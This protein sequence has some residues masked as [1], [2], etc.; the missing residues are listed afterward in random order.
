LQARL[1]P[2]SGVTENS[3]PDPG[4]C[5]F[6]WDDA[7]PYGIDVAIETQIW[8]VPANAPALA[9]APT[10]TSSSRFSSDHAPRDGVARHPAIDPAF[11]T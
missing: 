9:G 1:P 6:T 7:G 5:N 11:G 3:T 2:A 10:P 8:A 4:R